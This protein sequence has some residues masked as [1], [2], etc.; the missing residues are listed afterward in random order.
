MTKI[1]IGKIKID[2]GTQPREDIDVSIVSEYADAM[3]EGANFPPVVVFN[4]GVRYWLADGFHRYHASK[5]V[6]FID[7]DADVKQGT[8]RDAV[9]YSVGANTDHGLRRSNSDKRKAVLTLL[10]DDEW[11]QWTQTKISE[12]CGVSQQFVSKLVAENPQSSYNNSKIKKVKRGD[13]EYTV[14][15]DNIGKKPTTKI[16]YEPEF[17]DE[18]EANKPIRK[19]V[20]LE[21]AHEAIGKLKQIPQDDGLL[22]E[23]YDTVIQWIQNNR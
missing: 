18:Q 11:S 1:D 17:K 14:K 16:E 21:K 6:G 2:G 15:T 8:Q 13:Q 7:I 4:D 5:K 10:E 22:Q 12:Q 23:A 9:L 20:G 19:G 3:R